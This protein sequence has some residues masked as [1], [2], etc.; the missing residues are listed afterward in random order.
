MP[1]TQNLLFAALL[2]SSATA[3]AADTSDPSSKADPPDLS[4]KGSELSFHQDQSRAYLRARLPL[5]P[6]SPPVRRQPK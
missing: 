4:K 1:R 6:S 2:M 5:Q 3:F